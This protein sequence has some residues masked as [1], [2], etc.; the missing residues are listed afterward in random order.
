MKLF[1]KDW[2]GFVDEFNLLLFLLLFLVIVFV[3]VLVDL[4]EIGVEVEKWFLVIME[5]NKINGGELFSIRL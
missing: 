2:F 5:S 1:I 4:L 3:D